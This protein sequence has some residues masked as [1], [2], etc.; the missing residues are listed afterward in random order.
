MITPDRSSLRP[1]LAIDYDRYMDEINRTSLVYMP[2]KAVRP[3]YRVVH[4]NRALHNSCGFPLPQ[5]LQTAHP[6]DETR[7]AARDVGAAA[8]AKSAAG[9]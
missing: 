1:D 7:R 5:D 4:P 3:R 2:L 6:R 9:D 8:T